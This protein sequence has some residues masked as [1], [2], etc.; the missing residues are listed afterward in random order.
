[1]TGCLFGHNN[2]NQMKGQTSTEM[3]IAVSFLG[4]LLIISYLVYS[5][6]NR[7]IEWVSD[8]LEVKKICYEFSS[9]IN[10]VRMNGKG[11]REKISY[12]QDYNVTIE[13]DNRA[14]SID[15]DSNT[16]LCEF[17]TVNV[18]NQTSSRFLVEKGE[19]FVENDGELVVFQK[20]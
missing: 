14:I 3:M 5:E 16:V 20:I 17:S 2:G 18:T 7:D 8:F 13:G 9:V 11:F 12:N 19:Y 15:F 10:R 6:R 1:M 4:F